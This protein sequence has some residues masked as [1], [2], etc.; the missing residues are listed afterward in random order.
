MLTDSYGSHERVSYFMPET[1]CEDM[2]SLRLRCLSRFRFYIIS[3]LGSKR[4]SVSSRWNPRR[5]TVPAMVS[6]REY[7]NPQ[8]G[9]Q[10]TERPSIRARLKFNAGLCSQTYTR[11]LDFFLSLDGRR[12]VEP[13]SSTAKSRIPR[14]A[15]RQTRGYFQKYPKAS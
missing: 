13:R 11:V 6:I 2:P 7:S 8:S 15:P 10:R 4:V 3:V 1:E 14:Y 9:E 5:L 12:E